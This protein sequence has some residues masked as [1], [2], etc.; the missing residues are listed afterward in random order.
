MTDR[1]RRKG[2][3]LIELLVVMT[4]IALLLSIVAPRYFKSVS[5]A[6]EAVLKQDLA[7][8][9]DALDKYHADTGK[10][11]DSLDDLVA[12]Q[13]IRAIPVDP[14]TNSATTW[15]VLPPASTERGKVFDIKSSAPSVAKDGSAY[16]DW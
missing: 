13:Y 9:R 11:P 16:S 14:I 12:K 10:Y 5:K 7:T 3:T 15:V 4:V 1:W 8:M 2:F 6:K